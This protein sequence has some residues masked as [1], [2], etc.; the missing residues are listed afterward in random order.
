MATDLDGLSIKNETIEKS[1]SKSCQF[2]TNTLLAIS[3]KLDGEVADVT[4]KVSSYKGILQAQTTM[5]TNQAD[6]ID[7]LTKRVAKMEKRTMG[8]DESAA[9]NKK[10]ETKL[11]DVKKE[12]ERMIKTAFENLKSDFRFEGIDNGTEIHSAE[13]IEPPFHLIQ[14]YN[15]LVI[16]D[17]DVADMDETQKSDVMREKSMQGNIMIRYKTKKQTEYKQAVV[18][19]E[20]ES[21]D[22]LKPTVQG[23][24]QIE[25]DAEKES[26]F[27]DISWQLIKINGVDLSTMS[28]EEVDAQFQEADY[29]I[30][31]K[32]FVGTCGTL[33]AADSRELTSLLD[34]VEIVQINS[35]PIDMTTID[36]AFIDA[37]SWPVVVD[38][39]AV[40]SEMVFVSLPDPPKWKFKSTELAPIVYK[41]NTPALKNGV[42]VTSINDIPLSVTKSHADVQ[43][44]GSKSAWLDTVQAFLKQKDDIRLI[45]IKEY[46]STK[47]L[48][49]DISSSCRSNVMTPLT[50]RK[51]KHAR[52]PKTRGT[53]NNDIAA[54]VK[55]QV[56]KKAEDIINRCEFMLNKL[57]TEIQK[58]ISDGEAKVNEEL[59][60]IYE[61]IARSSGMTE[62]EKE[63]IENLRHDQQNLKDNLT[64]DVKTLTDQAAV[65]LDRLDNHDS[66]LTTKF[67]TVDFVIRFN[68]LFAEAIGK[69]ENAVNELEKDQ[70]GQRTINEENDLKLVYLENCFQQ[71]E[72]R[73]EILVN[74]IH[75]LRKAVKKCQEAIEDNVSHNPFLANDDL[76]CLS[77]GVNMP[78]TFQ[79]LPIRRP[80]STM[81]PGMGIGGGFKFQKTA[82]NRLATP[83]KLMELGKK[84]MTMSKSMPNIDYNDENGENQ[85]LNKMDTY[86]RD[87]R[88]KV[89]NI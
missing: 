85:Q 3:G 79:A 73:F 47:D 36:Q 15:I 58:Q 68:E 43:P 14:K 50:S 63:M 86:L 88:L 32:C 27:E 1:V 42:E 20:A 60:G 61:D 11:Q 30:E 83:E 84:S 57:E 49:S 52:I 44:D 62:D 13:F 64:E 29:P 87:I 10:I 37:L 80:K 8:D 16:A 18:M 59:G 41:S 77:C 51:G 39:E 23:A 45:G 19:D 82:K 34:S 33:T 21:F 7:K 5:I 66:V 75:S 38:W 24:T 67:D 74:K 72:N 78:Q 25:R 28:P 35:K 31:L 22:L 81:G 71:H 65:Q 89:E 26:D 6:T 40:G 4:K 69:I 56:E 48:K 53:D 12:V 2:L 54:M 55:K 76:F 9:L 70:A 46:E 17:V